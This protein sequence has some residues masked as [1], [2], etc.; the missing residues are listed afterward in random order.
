LALVIIQPNEDFITRWRDLK[1]IG[2]GWL[3]G[4]VLYVAYEQFLRRIGGI[5]LHTLLHAYTAL[6]ESAGDFWPI[7]RFDPKSG[8][9]SLEPH[10]YSLWSMFAADPAAYARTSRAALQCVFGQW[11]VVLCGIHVL[12]V[13]RLYVSRRP[14]RDTLAICHVTLVIFFV[15]TTLIICLLAQHPMFVP[16]MYDPWVVCSI[17]VLGCE[18]VRRVGPPAHT[19][20][21]LRAGRVAVVIVLFVSQYGNLHGWLEATAKRHRQSGAISAGVIE[22]LRR[23]VPL[24]ETVIGSPVGGPDI[25]V[26]IAGYPNM[27]F[28]GPPETFRVQMRA[29]GIRFALVAPHVIPNAN[30]VMSDC[31]VE[32]DSPFNRLFHCPL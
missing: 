2:Y 32:F 4:V 13:L 26:S 8:L 5:P 28:A 11:F 25:A 12:Q 6:L 3:S 17:A 15:L 23:H 14:Q 31:T 19:S 29:H 1:I 16:R 18:F 9:V 27:Q 7:H 10:A 24:G 20:A 22:A 30:A 21:C